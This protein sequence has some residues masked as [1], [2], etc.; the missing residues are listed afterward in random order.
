MRICT[1]F[2][3]GCCFS[4]IAIRSLILFTYAFLGF[5]RLGRTSIFARVI[6]LEGNVLK[7]EREGGKHLQV[8]LVEERILYIAR[9]IL[10]QGKMSTQD[11]CS[12]PMI[13][14]GLLVLLK[15]MHTTNDASHMLDGLSGKY[16][17]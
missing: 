7:V 11:L 10:L 12:V 15:H 9:R 17:W 13:L 2:F 8:V 1:I 6:K 14:K 16:A 5:L 3:N 4:C